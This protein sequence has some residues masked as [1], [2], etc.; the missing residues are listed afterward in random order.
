MFAHRTPKEAEAQAGNSPTIKRSVVGALQLKFWG[1]L[2]H[3]HTELHEYSARVKG[4]T[5]GLVLG[6]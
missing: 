5:C 4:K 2:G 3:T 1:L 6:V